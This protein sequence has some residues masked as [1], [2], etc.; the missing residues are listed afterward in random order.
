[1]A[2]LSK[3]A[4]RV[5]EYKSVATTRR[6]KRA[7]DRKRAA[8]GGLMT[9]EPGRKIEADKL[10]ASATKMEAQQKQAEA[11]AVKLAKAERAV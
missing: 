3:I 9:A 11:R 4:R 2:Q 8:N 6:A 10:H 5:Q 1:M 7:N